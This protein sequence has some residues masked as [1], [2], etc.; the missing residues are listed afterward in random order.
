MTRRDHLRA[1]IA[2][3]K[4]A[5]AVAEDELRGI[6]RAAL[7]E[8]VDKVVVRGRWLTD[9]RLAA[10]RHFVIEDRMM[11]HQY[12]PLLRRMPGPE[13]PSDKAVQNRARSLRIVIPI[14]KPEPVAPKP[15]PVAPPPVVVAP[16]KPEGIFTTKTPSAP[17]PGFSMGAMAGPDPMAEKWRA[18]RAK[19]HV[20]RV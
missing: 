15:A 11:P 10:L 13:M 5:L 18:E 12:C 7:A 1:R 6:E 4:R 3:I 19:G 17:R 14:A 20:G 2:A 16:A 8:A 9:D